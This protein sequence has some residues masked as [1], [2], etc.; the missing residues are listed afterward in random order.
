M[1]GHNLAM[2]A[3]DPDGDALRASRVRIVP[4]VGEWSPQNDPAAFADLLLR[5]LDA[6]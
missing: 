6:G 5:V 4:A 2:P 1:L 3:Y